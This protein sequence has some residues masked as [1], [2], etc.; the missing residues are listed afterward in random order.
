MTATI[1]PDVLARYGSRNIPRY[2]SYPTAPHFRPAPDIGL[3]REWLAAVPADEPVSLYVHVPFCRAM[4][5]YCGCHTSVTHR[6]APIDRYLHALR[7]ELAAVAAALPGRVP[8]QHLHFGG[9]TP[10]LM[11]PDGFR[12]LMGQLRA[13]FNFRTDAEVAIEIDPRTLEQPMIE[14]LAAGGVNRASLGVQSF[15]LK[16]QQAINRVQSFE[17]T[18]DAV[19]G[20]RRHGIDQL[21]FDLIYGLPHQSVES[22]IDTLRQAVSLRPDRLAVFGYAH[23]PGFKPHQRKI[24][25]STLGRA[26]ERLAQAEAIARALIY[27][28]YV[29]IG[30]DH[31]ALP[32]D[33]LTLAAARGQLRRNFQG[34]TTDACTTLL[35]FGASAIGRVPDGFVQNAV[36]IPDY[37]KRIR[38]SGL[39][40]ARHCPTD[41]EDR[42]RGAL[43]EQL[44]C[45]YR[46][47]LS[48][49]GDLVD[50]TKLEP[51]VSDGIIRRKGSVIEVRPEARPLVRAVAAA[52]DAYLDEGAG[53]HASAV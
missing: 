36:L 17:I 53:R 27:A 24:D 15:D 29:P 35:G 45:Q 18:R 42:R 16:V 14:A 46:A 11:E 38:D 30:L 28:G 9:G 48:G 33:P 5:W 25:E 21:N 7:S 10:T 23:V 13:A 52:F 49:A 32:G 20:L 50:E 12:R 47:D 44:M 1:D 51:L 2:T 3:Y 41:G 37:E 26:A 34:Y 31:F 39:A 6:D 43:I 8:V 40:L 4:C 22:C 19:K